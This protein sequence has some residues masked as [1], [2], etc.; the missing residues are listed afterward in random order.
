MEVADSPNSVDIS[1][2]VGAYV[3]V[4]GR[5]NLHVPGI[6]VRRREMHTNKEYITS[7][8]EHSHPQNS[9]LAGKPNLVVDIQ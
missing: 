3:H 7:W 4:S 8:G 2:V 9:R 1:A 6:S 5:E